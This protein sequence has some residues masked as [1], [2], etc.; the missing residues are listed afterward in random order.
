MK[1]NNLT[2]KGTIDY[3]MDHDGWCYDIMYKSF[4]CVYVR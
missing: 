4:V 3:C 1:M 2:T